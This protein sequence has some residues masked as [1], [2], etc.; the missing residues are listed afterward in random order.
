VKH[1]SPAEALTALV[2]GVTAKWAKQRKAE[3]RDAGARQRRYDRLIRFQRP[4]SLREA[5]WRVLPQAYAAAS[6]DVGAHTPDQVAVVQ[7]LC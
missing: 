7:Q 5:A 2:E 1:Q 3:E 4:V 6:G